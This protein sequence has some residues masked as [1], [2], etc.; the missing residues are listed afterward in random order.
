MAALAFNQSQQSEL[1]ISTDKQCMRSSEPVAIPHRAASLPKNA[2]EID[3]HIEKPTPPVKQRN[4]PRLNAISPQI[5]SRTADPDLNLRTISKVIEPS[6]SV[7]RS[8]PRTCSAS[9]RRDAKIASR[10]LRI[11]PLAFLGAFTLL[12]VSV[13]KA[14]T[15]YASASALSAFNPPGTPVT[16]FESGFGPIL[17]STVASQLPSSPSVSTGST[18]AAANAT[19]SYGEIALSET[20]L[21]T[22]PSQGWP[23]G[24][25][26]A[27]GCASAQGEASGGFTDTWTFFGGTG[28]VDV[29]G[30]YLICN[31]SGNASQ[32]ISPVAASTISAP[33][34]ITFGVPFTI[35]ASATLQGFDST[36]VDRVTYPGFISADWQIQFLISDQ[37]EFDYTT[38]S[39]V[40]YAGIVGGT[41]ITP[42]PATIISAA[43]LVVSI[44]GWRR[45]AY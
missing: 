43:F 35:S 4:L 36:D 23:L 8:V 21:V 15:L 32:C 44:L 19:V 1:S 42:E 22:A 45:H 6:C 10:R 11:Y 28:T 33:S 39:G 13:T 9:S 37:S 14:S 5:R 27:P 40:P 16:N 2:A 29:L 26:T 12:W 38:A 18:Q 7:S 30:A 20:S 3:F 25:D 31:V 34:Q 24:C 17:T 41:Y